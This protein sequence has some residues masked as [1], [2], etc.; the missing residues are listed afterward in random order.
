MR[1]CIV[2]TCCT[3]RILYF[4]LTELNVTI[5]AKYTP[6]SGEDPGELGPNEFRAGTT[7]SLNCI[8]QGN[9]GDVY[10]YMVCDGEP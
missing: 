10:I 1:E 3:H 7:L 9:G 5:S 8:V 6:A 2:G 4:F